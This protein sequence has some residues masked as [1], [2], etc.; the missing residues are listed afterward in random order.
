MNDK[1]KNLLIANGHELIGQ[2]SWPK[3]GGKKWLPYTIL[4]AREELHSQL[5]G[6]AKFAREMPPKFAP[7]GEVTAKVVLHPSFL[8]KT[9]FPSS[10][11]RDSGL[12]ILG[13][14]PVSVSPRRTRNG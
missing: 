9:Y 3:G 8:A 1:K 14:R 6:L 4:D 12:N 10:I 7:R 13:S 11:L 2:L 5:V